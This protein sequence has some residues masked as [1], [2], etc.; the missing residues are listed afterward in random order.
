MTVKN[1]ILFSNY[2]FLVIGV[3]I[4]S[5]L[6]GTMIIWNHYNTE[7]EIDLLATSEARANVNKDKAFRDWATKHGGVYVPPNERTPPNPYLAHI[8]DR[9]IVSTDGKEYTLMN[10]AYM[11]RQMTEEFE[12]SYGVKGKLTGKILLNPL[13]KPDPWELAC[14]D[15]FES[16]IMEI[17]SK[18]NIG[19]E[20]YLR[21]MKPMYM[22]KGCEKC[23]AHLGFKEGDLR[24]GVSVS[25]PLNQYYHAASLRNNLMFYTYVIIWLVGIFAIVFFY[26]KKSRQLDQKFLQIRQYFNYFD[27]SSDAILII[28]D[29]KFIDCNRSTVKMLGFEKKEDL[30]NTHPSELSPPVQPDGRDSNE[31]ADEMMKIALENGSHHFEWDHKKSNGDIFPVEVVLTSTFDDSNESI[32]H[33]V[34]RDITEHKRAEELIIKSKEQLSQAQKIAKVGSWYMDLITN[35]IKWS[36]QMFRLFDFEKGEVPTLD[37]VREGILK[38]DLAL[39]DSAFESLGEGIVL[40]KLDYRYERIKGNLKYFS[41][42]TEATYGDNGEI[43]NLFGTIQDVTEKK[44]TDD[45]IKTAAISFSSV[46]GEEYFVE[47]CK[48]LTETLDINIAFVGEFID[49]T[50]VEI[51]GGF[52]GGKILEPFIYDLENTPCADVLDRDICCFSSGVQ[53]LY[54]K[55]KLAVELDVEGY[56]GINLYGL[57]AT[58]IGIIVLLSSKPILNEK[59][60]STT[61]QIFAD[62]VSAELL[63]LQTEMKLI[64]SEQTYRNL[65]N[66]STDAIYIQDKEGK[67]IDVSEGVLKMYGYPKEYFIGNTPDFLSAPGRNDF[68]EVVRSMQLAMG[69]EPRQ[70]EFWGIRKNGEVFP[71]WVR[72]QKGI[73]FGEDALIVYSID[74]TEQKRAEDEIKKSLDE[75]ETMLKEIHHRVKNNLQVISGLLDLQSSFI[76][77][78]QSLRMFEESQNRIKSMALVHELLY[79]SEDLSKVNFAEYVSTLCDQ[80]YQS[81]ALDSHSIRL[82]IDIP[83]GIFLKIHKAIPCGLIINELLSNA[84][85]YAFPEEKLDTDNMTKEIIIRLYPSKNDHLM[86]TVEDNGTGFPDDIDFRDTKSLGLTLVTS[87]VNQISGVIELEKN[88]GSKFMIEFENKTR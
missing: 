17:I 7:K 2:N 30:L 40:E 44:Q 43:L 41:T 79:G 82:K 14:L 36:D 22:E 34:W 10:P 74:I 65:I 57:D 88:G 75:K 52:S 32:I 80:L 55:D 4:W 9:D 1:D 68:D 23:H 3:L 61:L 87:L 58:P 85:K 62:R 13:N 18:E 60:A 45:I 35:K 27:K 29:G 16:G 28:K 63:R 8:P 73:F 19:G 39:Y 86:L 59:F 72:M 38:E 64:E 24:G 67:F 76:G 69:G 81:F 15:S 26:S 70:F 77:D 20:P 53:K 46:T 56:L 42:K 48:Y 49:Y 11:M 50:K 54:P 51:L 6:I 5:T 37:E 12:E 33:T 31:K 25:I 83:E 78:E 71:K 66:N 47:V 21:L 84:M